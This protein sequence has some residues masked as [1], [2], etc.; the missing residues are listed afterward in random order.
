MTNQTFNEKLNQQTNGVGNSFGRQNRENGNDCRPKTRASPHY[1]SNNRQQMKYQCY[2]FTKNVSSEERKEKLD[3]LAK[4]LESDRL[5]TLI[6]NQ[7]EADSHDHDIDFL[8]E[9]AKEDRIEDLYEQE[10]YQL[11]S[12]D[13]S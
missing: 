12:G 1:Q 10:G 9:C 7:V 13:Y 8:E 5:E 4:K 3:A 6:L 11:A 2:D